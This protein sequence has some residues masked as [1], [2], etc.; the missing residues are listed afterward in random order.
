[1]GF[2][3][4]L[5]S[6]AGEVGPPSCGLQVGGLCSEPPL[7]DMLACSVCACLCWLEAFLL[8][9]PLLSMLEWE[10][11]GQAIPTWS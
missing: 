6:M 7:G 1:M 5:A 10:E 2:H 8:R 4:R 9:G 3:G 11:T